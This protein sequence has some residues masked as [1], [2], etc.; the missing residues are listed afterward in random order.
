MRRKCQKQKLQQKPASKQHMLYL[1]PQS[2]GWLQ[3]LQTW[4]MDND[5]VRK[6]NINQ[7]VRVMLEHFWQLFH[8]LLDHLRVFSR[9]DLLKRFNEKTHKSDWLPYHEWLAQKDQDRYWDGL[10]LNEREEIARAKARQDCLTVWERLADTRLQI[11]E[12]KQQIQE[13]KEGHANG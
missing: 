5:A 13:L 4:L 1:D 12:Q 7:L 8:P 2:D 10:T 6:V 3:D 9:A 11:K